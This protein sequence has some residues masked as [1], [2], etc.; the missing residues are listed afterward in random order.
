MIA[1][2]IPHDL[3]TSDFTRDPYIR[4]GL[5]SL[6]GSALWRHFTAQGFHHLI[7]RTSNELDL[8][9]AHATAAIFAAA[10]PDMV[11]NAGG[12]VGGI[13]ANASRPDDFYSANLRIQ[14]TR[15]SEQTFA[16]SSVAPP[17]SWLCALAAGN[18]PSGDPSTVKCT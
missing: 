3:N 7:G 10:R 12:V 14:A 17:W 6:V 2:D 8:W 1:V 5:Q 9:D 11:I 4:G 13:A 18:G 16:E 15:A